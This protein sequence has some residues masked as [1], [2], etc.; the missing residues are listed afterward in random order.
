ML[1][2]KLRCRLVKTKTMQVNPESGKKEYSFPCMGGVV[3]AECK[4][5]HCAPAIKPD[6]TRLYVVNVVKW[7]PCASDCPMKSSP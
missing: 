6:A 2:K 4:H 5:G 1:S 7:N 3:V